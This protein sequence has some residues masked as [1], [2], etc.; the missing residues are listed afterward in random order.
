MVAVKSAGVPPSG[1]TLILAKAPCN[2]GVFRPALIAAL[3]LPTTACGV[4]AGARSP[5][6]ATV[7]KSGKPLSIMVGTSGNCGMRFCVVTASGR[8]LARLDQRHQHARRLE[9]HL[10]IAG[11]QIG[12]RGS[13]AFI[14]H[15]HDVDAGARLEQ[16][17]GEMGQH[18][19]AARGKIDL[20]RIGLGI[21]DELGHRMRRHPWIDD[22]NARAGADE[23]DRFEAFQRVIAGIGMQQRRDDQ[24]ARGRE[25]KRIAVGG[26]FGGVLG[27]D[28]VAGP[29]PVFDDKGLAERGL[30]IIGGDASDHVDRSAGRRRYDYFDRTARIVLRAGGCGAEH[31]T[32]NR[33]KDKNP[34][35][36]YRTSPRHHRFPFDISS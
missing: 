25:Q 9:G 14:G 22:K 30:Q 36:P 3:S 2:S 1:S 11:H 34:C 33:A 31:Q 4:C 12:D 8:E 21:G 13:A 29:G 7:T 17:T 20:A 18:A 19:D 15:V 16:L 32:E 10:H 28:R 35:S 26:G 23:C 6:Q 27:A 24:P 5:V